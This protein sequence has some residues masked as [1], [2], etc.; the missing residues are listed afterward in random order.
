[1][2]RVESQTAMGK[3]MSNYLVGPM[4]PKLF[5]DK[6]F[7]IDDLPGIKTVPSFETGCYNRTVAASLEVLAYDPFV[8]QFS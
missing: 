1:M 5:L 8:S 6:F 3:E 2:F 7:P 4:P